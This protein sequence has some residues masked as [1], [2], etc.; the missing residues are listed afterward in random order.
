MDGLRFRGFEV[1]DPVVEDAGQQG[2][3]STK[4]IDKVVQCR[5]KPSLDLR[6]MMESDI[7]ESVLH[8]GVGKALEGGL[9]E[10]GCVFDPVAQGGKDLLF[11]QTPQPGLHVRINDGIAHRLDAQWHRFGDKCRV[12]AIE[13][14]HLPQAVGCHVGGAQDGGMIEQIE[15]AAIFHRP[16]G[17]RLRDRQQGVLLEKGMFFGLAGDDAIHEGVHP[18]ALL[19]DPRQQHIGTTP[20]ARLLQHKAVQSL[21][22]VVHQL[23][24]QNREA[25]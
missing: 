6:L 7:S 22:I 8:R 18:V 9:S 3:L 13:N 19:G 15:I 2:R 16:Q 24:G 1:S 14:A 21:R 11:Q 12:S 20:S 17:K 10:A 25:L 5:S 23:T 4:A